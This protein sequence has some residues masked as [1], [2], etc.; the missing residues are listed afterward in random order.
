[1]TLS[2]DLLLKNA[3]IV[4]ET[5]VFEGWVGVADGRIAQVGHGD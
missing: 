2:L 3:R 1:M 4:T 5:R